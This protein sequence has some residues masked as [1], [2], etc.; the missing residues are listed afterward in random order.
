MSFQEYVSEG[1][2]YPVF[3]DDLVYKLGRVKCEVNFV[4][5]GSNIVKRIR[6][7]KYDPVIVERTI[8]LVLGPS[9]EHCTLNN[10]AMDF[11]TGLVNPPPPPMR[12]GPDPRP[13]S[14]L[15]RTPLVL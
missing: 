14:L 11:I 4:S 15:V 9:M 8:G 13:L 6:R 10:K 1:I 2:S 3:N 7:Q 5:L 12:R